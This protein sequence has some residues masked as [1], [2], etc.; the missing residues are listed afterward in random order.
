MSTIDPR[1]IGSKLGLLAAVA[2][3]VL[4]L[5]LPGIAQ[6]YTCTNM[7][8]S[9]YVDAKGPP[10]S[11]SMDD[12]INYTAVTY[13]AVAANPNKLSA[14]GYLTGVYC[15]EPGHGQDPLYAVIDDMVAALGDR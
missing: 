1:R 5:L 9:Q 8:A 6:A 11:P 7:V 10:F 15:G 12:M 13:P 3:F 2:M 4:L 14:V